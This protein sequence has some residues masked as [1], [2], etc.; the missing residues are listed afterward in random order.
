MSA[1]CWAAVR[2]SS[3]RPAAGWGRRT[4]RWE[5]EEAAAGG[6]GRRSAGP[7]GGG[8]GRRDEGPAMGGAGGMGVHLGSNG[9][10]G[11][12]PGCRTRVRRFSSYMKY[13]HF[14]PTMLGEYIFCTSLMDKV[15]PYFMQNVLLKSI[16]HFS[17]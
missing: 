16:I 7:V 2:R 3:R 1:K 9:V 14:F 8:G 5:L 15:L 13:F 10:G 12:W 4:G 11:V 6:G 17:F